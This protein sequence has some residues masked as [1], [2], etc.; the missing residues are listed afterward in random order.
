MIL[1]WVITL[2]MAVTLGVIVLTNRYA[3]DAEK[4]TGWAWLATVGPLALVT[5]LGR[6]YSR[7]ALDVTDDA[8]VAR[9]GFG[10]PTRRIAWS[11]VATVEKLYVHPMQWGGWGYRR[12]LLRKTTAAVM[13]SGEGLKFTFSDGRIFVVT[14]DNAEAGLTAIRKVLSGN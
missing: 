14:V 6:I 7:V 10:W 11:N 9:F 12:S 4:I 1:P 5:V 3:T 8:I 2:L 13:R